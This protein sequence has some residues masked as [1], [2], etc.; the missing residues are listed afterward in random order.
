MTT[1]IVV[2][3]PTSTNNSNYNSVYETL[4]PSVTNVGDAIIKGQVSISNLARGLIANTGIAFTNAN[5]FHICEP[6]GAPATIMSTRFTRNN[7]GGLTKIPQAAF[8]SPVLKLG[9]L[10]KSSIIQQIIQQIRS[11][12]E[13]QLFSAVSPITQAIRDAASYVANI[14][15]TVNYLLQIYNT[16]VAQVI[17]VEQYINQILNWIA[18]LPLAISAALSE[19]V[20]LLAAGLAAALSGALNISTGGLLAQAAALQRN[21]ATAQAYTSQAVSGA[22]AITTNIS[23]LGNNFANNVTAATQTVQNSL[24]NAKTSFSSTVLVKVV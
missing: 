19:C 10:L 3:A 6:F 2:L 23:N 7:F 21:I 12:I 22:Q 18:S 17:I 14:L 24:L 16:V 4:P 9:V 5:G 11:F 1:P 20:R 15:K 13:N 8:G